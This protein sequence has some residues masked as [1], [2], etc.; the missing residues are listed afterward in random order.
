MEDKLVIWRECMVDYNP[1]FSTEDT[2][3]FIKQEGE[4][5]GLSETDVKNLFDECEYPF[6]YDL[7]KKEIINGDDE[8]EEEKDEF[9]CELCKKIVNET[10]YLPSIE[11]DETGD[12]LGYDYCLDCYKKVKQFI[13]IEEIAICGEVHFAFTDR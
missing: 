9:E 4:V 7:T 10:E 5:Y 3:E 12:A 6:Y 11:D 2:L 1:S 13:Y 8:E